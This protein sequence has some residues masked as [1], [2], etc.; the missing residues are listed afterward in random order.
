MRSIA[1]SLYYCG[2][3]GSSYLSSLLISVITQITARS[4][5]R[6]WLPEDLNKGRLDNF[7]RILAAL[8]IVNLG[9]FV[10]C[11]RWYR[12][13]GT[14]SSSIELDKVTKQSERNANGVL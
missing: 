7:Y 10:L 11:A 14:D 4:K 6:N 12:Y 9:Y 1:G 13:K 8:E 5:S 3:A 2:H